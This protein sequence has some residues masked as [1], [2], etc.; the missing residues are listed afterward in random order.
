MKHIFIIN[1]VAGKRAG[2]QSITQMAE[3]LRA[4][5]GLDTECRFTEFP[6]HAVTLAGEFAA[7]GAPVRLYACG[8]DGTA[9]EVANGIAGCSNAAMTVIPIGTG[10]DLIKNF[11]AD[12]ARFSDI[13][14]LWYSEARPLDLIDCNGRLC[15]TIACSG[16]DARIA[17]DVHRF[18]S[19]PLLSGKGSYIASLL[20]NFLFKGIGSRWTVTVGDNP[21]DTGEYPACLRE[22]YIIKQAARA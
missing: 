19:L 10:N 6:G 2:T 4:R 7:S 11:G 3:H 9:G 5:H 17:Q 15:L 22:K 21:P 18:S 20:V 16:V 1:P 12:A 13:E 14:A 8:G